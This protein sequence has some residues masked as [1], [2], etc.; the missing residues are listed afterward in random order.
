MDTKEIR[1]ALGIFK[2]GGLVEVRAI[3]SR[4]LSGYFKDFDNCIAWL[5]RYPTE[6]FYFVMNEIRPD[7]YSR[8]QNE[9]LLSKPKGTTSDNDIIRRE[10]LLI[11]TDPKRVTGISSTDDEKRCAL[12]TS[13]KVFAYLRNTGF[14]A[15]V[16][17]DSGNGYHLLY[18]VDLKN[19]TGTADLVKGCL[20]ALDML[21]S[22]EHVTVDT[23]VYNASRITKL[24]GVDT[25]KGA[26]TPERPHRQSRLLSV[27]ETIIPVTIELLKKVAALVPEP[28]KPS[29]NQFSDSKFDIDGF[30]ARNGIRVARTA[31]CTGGT[32]YVLEECVFD[33]SHKSPDA[34]I[35][36][37]DNGALGYHCFHNTCQGKS[38]HDAREKFDPNAYDRRNQASRTTAPSFLK[39]PPEQ[40]KDAKFLRL[41]EISRYD[42]SQVVSVPSGFHALDKRIIGFNLG[43]ISIWSGGNG[44]GKSTILS[45][46][47]LESVHNGFSAAMFSGELSS[48]RMKS[49][50]QLQAAGRARTKPSRY[51]NVWYVPKDIGE[52]IDK[53]TGDKLWLYNND[54]GMDAKKV[55][56][57]IIAHIEQHHTDVMTIDNLMCLDMSKV[58]GDKYDKQS[59]LVLALAN[60]AKK[61]NIHIH[62]VCHPRKPNGF[63]R[64]ADIS[65][66]SDLTNA[67][68]NVFM[69]HR[70]NNDYRKLS[71]DFFDKGK[72]E[73][74]FNFSNVL[75]VMKNRD[76]GVEDELV[77]MYFEPESKR[78]LNQTG[79][80]KIYA[81][82]D[83]PFYEAA[84]I[85][86]EDNP[87]SMGDKDV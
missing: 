55:L 15:P 71:K 75:E 14:P 45:Q 16:V 25:H 23:S 11:D 51:D 59:A 76:L 36:V 22:D 78:L 63:L 84:D 54:Y 24:Y 3:G 81:W 77:G 9:K 79:D 61:Y 43:E 49:W 32:K 7:C 82:D 86:D 27:P 44:S 58:P 4:T 30:I 50:L 17:A 80:S 53:W 31:K 52:R 33:A 64:K 46:L 40:Q 41:A 35:F 83:I 48:H 87:F 74:Y 21:F 13:R 5:E 47:A 1:R 10:W 57:D 2:P 66:T 60:T 69:M 37:M 8:E 28:E 34:A 19:D 73:K 62:F 68:D 26:N 38:W 20:A 72:A 12:E 39:P 6:T 29:G 56:D 85:P 67:A 65:G 42:R 18:R 70:I